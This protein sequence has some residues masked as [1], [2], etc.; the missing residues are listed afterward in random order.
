MSR[1]SSPGRCFALRMNA[2][3]WALQHTFGCA[4]HALGGK[5]LRVMGS[6]SG[7]P[8]QR[9]AP[10][11]QGLTEKHFCHMTLVTLGESPSSTPDQRRPF[12]SGLRVLV[13]HD[14]QSGPGKSRLCTIWV[15]S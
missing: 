12:P 7:G 3:C 15:L 4:A 8:W 6:G 2:S 9:R 13:N 14:L 5:P 11:T 1:N 10:G